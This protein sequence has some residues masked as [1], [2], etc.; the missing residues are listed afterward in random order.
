AGP[1]AAPEPR[2]EFL[3]QLFEP[4]VVGGAGIHGHGSGTLTSKDESRSSPRAS[5]SAWMVPRSSLSGERVDGEHGLRKDQSLGLVRKVRDLSV[6]RPASLVEA[7]SQVNQE[8]PGLLT[9]SEL[10]MG[11]GQE[12]Q[13]YWRVL[14]EP[15]SSPQGLDRLPVMF[16]AVEGRAE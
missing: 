14:V 8:G 1:L 3:G 16:G 11:H 7:L 15:I 4:P 2:G 12:D 5:A 6:L 13:S 10:V 9:L